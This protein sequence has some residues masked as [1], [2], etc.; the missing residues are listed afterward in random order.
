MYIPNTYISTYLIEY[1]R[2]SYQLFLNSDSVILIIVTTMISKRTLF[3]VP[4]N[5]FSYRYINNFLRYSES[6]I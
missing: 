4:C 5:Q 2:F 3:H 1:M 6:S